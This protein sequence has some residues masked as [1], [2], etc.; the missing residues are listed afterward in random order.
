MTDQEEDDLDLGVLAAD[1]TAFSTYMIVSDFNLFRKLDVLYVNDAEIV[2]VLEKPTDNRVSIR[3]AYGHI[4]AQAALAGS[5]LRLFPPI[6]PSDIFTEAA[7]D[8]LKK[9]DEEEI[10]RRMSGFGRE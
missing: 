8:D 6:R 2:N 9:Q 10:M 4:A 5:R 1:L 7:L 3:R